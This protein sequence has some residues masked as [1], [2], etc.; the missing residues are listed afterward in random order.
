[1][2]RIL[3]LVL[4][5]MLLALCPALAEGAEAAGKMQTITG[6]DGTYSIEVPEDYLPMNAEFMKTLMGMEEMQQI[7]AQLMGVEDVSQLSVYFDALEKSNMLLVY[8]DDLT[9]NLN[10][11]V[12]AAELTLDEVVLYKALLDLTIK[13]QYLGL[14][15]AEESIH[16]MDIQEIAGRRWYGTRVEMMGMQVL[17]L[18]TVENGLQYTITFT[19]IDEDVARRIM[20]SF[21][22]MAAE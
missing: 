13:Q 2:K 1:M 21:V 7:I 8:S 16:T 20:E 3:S 9:G 12:I 22:F 14:G 4:A 17:S 11:Q 5:L 15:I 19:D 6:P 10:V 18:M